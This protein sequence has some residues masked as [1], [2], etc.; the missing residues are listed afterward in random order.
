MEP[1][2]SLRRSLELALI[3]NLMNS[4]QTFHPQFSKAIIF[5]EE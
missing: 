2:G 4:V 3:L 5:G 1:E